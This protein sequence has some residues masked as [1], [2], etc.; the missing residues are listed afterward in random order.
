MCRIVPYAAEHKEGMIAVVRSVYDE[1]GFT[2]EA[3]GYHADLYD[4]DR[5][6]LSRGW[7]FWVM[8]SGDDVIGCA[9]ASVHGSECELH[10]MYLS[11]AFRGRGLGRL[12]L[13]KVVEYGRARGCRRMRAW[14][15]VKLTLAHKLYSRLGFIQEG[16]RICDDPDQAR[17]YGF[18]KEP[19]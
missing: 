16:E 18:W 5:A 9:G 12:L 1:Y 4:I 19:L 13:E 7:M 15:D 11:P 10:R 17:E 6:Y 14:S 3:G 8:L 2:W